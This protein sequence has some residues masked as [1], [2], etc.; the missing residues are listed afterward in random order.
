M[1]REGGRGEGEEG[2]WIMR[3]RGRVEGH[4]RAE[5]MLGTMEK[6]CSILSASRV[7]TW[8]GVSKECSGRMKASSF[9]ALSA[10]GAQLA[11]S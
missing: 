10:L 11:K 8:Q 3:L 2:R 7:S 6:G 9:G 4:V 1:L 5:Y